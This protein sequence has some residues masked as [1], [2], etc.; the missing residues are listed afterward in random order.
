[1]GKTPWE[2]GPF[3]ARGQRQNPRGVRPVSET[4]QHQAVKNL[5]APWVFMVEHMPI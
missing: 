3:A 5:A 4:P 2:I 1:M